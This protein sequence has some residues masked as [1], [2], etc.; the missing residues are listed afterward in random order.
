MKTGGWLGVL[1]LAACV[2]GLDVHAASRRPVDDL[3]AKAI[4]YALAYRQQLTYLLATE[5]Y[6]QERLD[7]DNRRTGQRTLRGEMFLTW[8]ATEWVAVHDVAEVDGQP[9]GDR[10]DLA[11]LL[12]N[13]PAASVAR[14]LKDYNS[15]FNIGGVVRNFN[16]PTFALQVLDARHVPRFAFD[17]ARRTRQGPVT[18]VT[19]SFVERN[20]PTLII[21]RD[22]HAIF[23]SGE[24]LVEADTGRI[25]RTRLDY[26]DGQ[27]SGTLTTIFQDD[28]RV[29]LLVPVQFRERYIARRSGGRSETITGTA[30][31]SDYHRFEATTRIR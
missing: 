20:P 6:S 9:V 27:L 19:L 15:R 21:G 28:A 29:N 7:E 3:V 2:I 10:Q 25:H 31:Y 5:H 30:L 11:T 23:S 17:V 13:A 4:A 1:L 26:L 22:G 24:F 14:T 12:R 18:L 8:A 16:E